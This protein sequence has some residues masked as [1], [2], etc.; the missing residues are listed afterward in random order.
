VLLPARSSSFGDV[1]ANK[2]GM[3]L[4]AVLFLGISPMLTFGVAGLSRRCG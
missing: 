4:G 3:L 1:V 2:A